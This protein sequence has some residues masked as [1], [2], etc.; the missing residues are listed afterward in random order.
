VNASTVDWEKII[1]VLMIA[2]GSVLVL[3]GLIAKRRRPRSDDSQKEEQLA[4]SSRS[5][6][7]PLPREL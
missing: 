2:A 1:A 6:M 3:I 4:D 5:R 7:A